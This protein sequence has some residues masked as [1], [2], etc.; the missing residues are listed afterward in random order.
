MTIIEQARKLYAQSPHLECFEDDVAAHVRTGYVFVTPTSILLGRAVPRDADDALISDPWHAF[1][2][3]ECDAWFVWLA[4][5]NLPEITS[6]IPYEQKWIAFARKGRIRWHGFHG[7]FTR[8][9]PSF[10]HDLR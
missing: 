3:S 5:G 7:R 2:P 9:Q 8:F 4:V 6:F 10:G 1:A